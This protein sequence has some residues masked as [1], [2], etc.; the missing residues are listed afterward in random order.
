VAVWVGRGVRPVLTFWTIHLRGGG[1][2]P[3]CVLTPCYFLLL[4]LCGSELRKDMGK[5][6]GVA[7]RRVLSAGCQVKGSNSCGSYRVVLPVLA[8][9][10]PQ[11]LAA[12]ETT[13][14]LDIPEGRYPETRQLPV[15]R[16]GR[17]KAFRLRGRAHAAPPHLAR[18]S[19]A[20]CST[21]Y[22]RAPQGSFFSRPWICYVWAGLG[23][24]RPDVTTTRGSPRTEQVR[25]RT[26]AHLGTVP[27]TGRPRSSG[28]TTARRE[29]TKKVV[30]WKGVHP[31]TPAAR[32]H[33]A[34]R[35][36]PPDPPRRAPPPPACAVF[37][38]S[39]TARAAITPA[40]DVSTTPLHVETAAAALAAAALTCSMT[41]EWADNLARAFDKPA[42]AASTAADEAAVPGDGPGWAGTCPRL[43][44]CP[45]PGGPAANRW[46]PCGCAV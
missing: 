5:R 11:S 46:A 34:R 8:S 9:V 15:Q 40:A 36:P 4:H 19:S 30:A 17:A 21:C 18:P 45:C 32:R 26:Q 10:P 43:C 24:R 28:W 35:Q 3:S 16:R 44:P 25:G 29:E 27:V 22:G 39:N 41:R 42:S 23:G 13:S 7:G 2:F 1:R 12:F 38:A 6:Q 20:S 37:A 14:Q 33:T 31:S